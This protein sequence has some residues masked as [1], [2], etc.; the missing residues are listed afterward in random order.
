MLVWFPS[1]M[2]VEVGALCL[3]GLREKPA[4]TP[5]RAAAPHFYAL[6]AQ[7]RR[8]RDQQQ[9]AVHAVNQKRRRHWLDRLRDRLRAVSH[10]VRSLGRTSQ[11]ESPTDDL[12][13]NAIG[14]LARAEAR[15][16]S[17]NRVRRKGDE[18]ESRGDDGSEPGDSASEDSRFAQL[19]ERPATG[20]KK[21]LKNCK[22]RL[23]ILRANCQ[24]RIPRFVLRT[25]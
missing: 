13:V 2:L 4:G 16:R 1:D 10:R 21:E 14:M 18:R 23:R 11:P 24:K 15:K 7:R 19:L 22:K 3:N 5:V 25:N 20:V 12:A 6:R 17:R 8:L 9:G